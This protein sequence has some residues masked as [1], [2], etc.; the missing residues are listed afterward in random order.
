MRFSPAVLRRADIAR[1]HGV[2]ERISV[3]SYLNS[4]V[5]FHRIFVRVQEPSA[6]GGHGVEHT[7]L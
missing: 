1:L 6:A 7:D 2:N 3:Q 4:I 5:F